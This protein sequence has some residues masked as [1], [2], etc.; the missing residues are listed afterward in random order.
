VVLGDYHDKVR[1]DTGAGWRIH[2]MDLVQHFRW[3]QALSTD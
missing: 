1:F 2:A 3:E